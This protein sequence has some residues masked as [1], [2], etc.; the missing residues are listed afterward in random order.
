MRY[1]YRYGGA[2]GRAL[3]I[4][5]RDDLLV[6]RTRDRGPLE[7][8]RLRRASREALGA[9]TPRLA[10]PDA[11]VE[12]W[13]ARAPRGARG[14][15]DRARA[16]LGSERAL[17]FAGRVLADPVSGAPVLYTE[18]LFVRFAAGLPT[19]RRQALL[20]SAGLRV[21]E[22]LSF[23]E[24]SVFVAAP[25]RTGRAVF[26]VAA[27]LLASGEVELCHP[28]LVRERRRRAFFAPQWHLASTVVG[29]RNIKASA[30][31]VAAW[32]L[33]RGAGVRIAVIDDGCDVRHPELSGRGKV[34]AAWDATRRVRSAAHRRADEGHGT[35]CCGVAAAAGRVGASGVAPEATLMPIRLAAAL[36]AKAEARAFAWAADHGADVISCSW[37][38]TD[39][40]FL[41]PGDPAH[42]AR[43][44]LPDST[45]LA[46][47]HASR[48]GRGGKGCVI[49]W[50]AGNGN[51]P[52]EHD[53]YASSPEVIAV[54]A[55]NDRSRKSAYSD[56]GA[57]VWCAFPS[58]DHPW[59]EHAGI[60]TTDR[61]GAA[62][63]NPGD[64][65]LGDASGDFTAQFGG[66]S[67]A[68]PGVAGVVALLLAR[69][70]DL[71]AVAVRDVLRRACVRIDR[72]GGRYDP[73]GHSPWYG[74]GRVDAKKAVERAIGMR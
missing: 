41:R 5:E 46:I 38:P 65:A 10:F 32:A 56:H 59:D 69:R 37:G 52:V 3:S 11:G 23:C 60:W 49:V 42:R 18:N 1:R 53:G 7:P 51:E 48:A 15:R 45:R 34:V 40:D 33:S 54:A 66:T 47:E 62:G 26:D 9:F 58:D 74:W 16:A 39:G 63:D 22:A 20:A 6:V 12:V 35:A 21:Q 31:V 73:R 44:A 24:R 14:D 64:P 57:A 50:A 28:E 68:C 72:T 70:P 4:V 29:G 67:S 36:G 19:R 8:T 55:C 71:T 2:R 13:Q 25:A 43:V 27:R 61:R 17:E 30:N